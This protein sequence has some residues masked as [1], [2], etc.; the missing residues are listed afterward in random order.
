LGQNKDLDNRLMQLAANSSVDAARQ[1]IREGADPHARAADGRTGLHFA[2]NYAEYNYT[3]RG[4]E[5]LSIFLN[6]GV[7]INSGDASGATALHYAAL[8]EGYHCRSKIEDLLN[9]GADLEARDKQGQT[10]LH[11]AALRGK[12]TDAIKLLL[13]AGAVVNVRDESGATPLHMAAARGDAEVIKML[14]NAGADIHAETRDGKHVWDFAV[15]AGQ[16]YQA[17]CLKAEAAKQ[18]RL[19]SQKEQEQAQARRRR[20]EEK[21]VDPWSLLTP[22]KIAVTKVE[23]QIGYRMT[24]VFNFAART[25]TQISQNLSTKSEAVAVKTFD[26]FDDKTVLVQAFSQLERLGG[27]ADRAAITGPV[28]EKP[29]KGL[30][31]PKAT[32]QR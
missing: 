29:R 11:H 18:L 1:I 25:Y 15:E 13:D 22:D 16:D 9:F 4:R 19:A 28:V 21:A 14:L 12:K 6:R 5:M 24:E 2:I 8:D 20:E 10:P 27:Q 7:D 17:Q 23:K 26:E 32:G 31:L 30:S 3:S